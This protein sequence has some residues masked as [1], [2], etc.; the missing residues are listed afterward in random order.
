MLRMTT[1]DYYGDR[2]GYQ[3]DFLALGRRTKSV[4]LRQLSKALEKLATRLIADPSGY[5]LPYH[6]FSVV[7]HARDVLQ[8]RPQNR[9]ATPTL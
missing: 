7:M 5:A 4:F 9:S 2:R 6:G 3:A 8:W 1:N